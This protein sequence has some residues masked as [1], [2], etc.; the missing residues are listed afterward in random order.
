[1]IHIVDGLLPEPHN[2]QLLT[3]LYHMSKWHA[4]AKLRM[5]TNHTLGTL[6]K[7]TAAIGCELQFFQKWSKA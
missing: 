7:A 6:D 1:M 4:L 2:A 5:H 3:L